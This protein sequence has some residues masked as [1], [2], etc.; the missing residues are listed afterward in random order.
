M[1]RLGQFRRDTLANWQ[2]QN[3]ILADGEFIL[4]AMDSSKPREY[5]KWACGNGTSTFTQLVLKDYG[6]EGNPCLQDLGNSTQFPISQDLATKLINITNVFA[7]ITSE[8]KI[9]IVGNTLYLG[10]FRLIIE[11]FG[12]IDLIGNELAFTITDDNSKLVVIDYNVLKNNLNKISD[13]IYQISLNTTG[14]IKL[15]EINDFNPNYILLLHKH[16]FK[17]EPSGILY[18]A[19]LSKRININCETDIDYIYRFNFSN[20]K[21]ELKSPGFYIK[22]SGYTFYIGMNSNINFNID[23]NKKQYLI[24]QIDECLKYGIKKSANYIE[25]NY[26]NNTNCIKLIS[27]ADIRDIYNKKQLNEIIILGVW[28]KGTYT[29][30]QNN[31]ITKYQNDKIVSASFYFN[32]TPT[33]FFSG[34]SLIIK[35]GVLFNRY[36]GRSFYLLGTKILDGSSNW[37]LDLNVLGKTIPTKITNNYDEYDINTENLIV[38]NIDEGINTLETNRYILLINVYNDSIIRNGGLFDSFINSQRINNNS[39]EIVIKNGDINYIGNTV[40]INKLGFRF[41]FPFWN[42]R[43]LIEN[44]SDEKNP[45]IFNLDDKEVVCLNLSILFEQ[46]NFNGYYYIT[47]LK[48][49]LFELKTSIENLDGYLPLFHS[50]YG[51][52]LPYSGLFST[53]LLKNGKNSDIFDNSYTFNSADTLNAIT[54][55][56]YKWNEEDLSFKKRF[57][58]GFIT[59]CHIESHPNSTENLQEA[60][61][62]LNSLPIKEE[63][64]CIINGGDNVSGQT[65]GNTQRT[66]MKLF[67]EYNKISKV[68]ILPIEG[69]H[70]NNYWKADGTPNEIENCI[71]PNEMR[72]ILTLPLIGNLKNTNIAEDNTYFY[73]DYPDFKIRIIIL[74]YCDT[75]LIE[76]EDGKNKYGKLITF[77]QK[78]INWFINEALNIPNEYGVIVCNHAPFKYGIGGSF[79]QNINMIPEIINAFK[80]GLNINKTFEDISQN[81]FD[82]VVNHDFTS[83]GPQNFMFYLS[84]HTHREYITTNGTYTDQVIV[85]GLNCA[86]VQE[87]DITR[88][89]NSVSKI[90]FNIF[91]IDK[92]ERK[93]YK[94]LYGAWQN[95][96]GT[97]TRVS[98]I[99]F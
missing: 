32:N 61:R 91:C 36:F 73:I 70:D 11:S 14:L 68:P 37:W 3:P 89:Q 75:P 71:S 88:I 25:I 57:N 66:N 48:E 44:S 45:L 58:I 47:E 97:N 79:A 31:L 50:Y 28:T 77:S 42:K 4:I 69:N 33:A 56:F 30:I 90:A 39:V 20:N 52:V 83:K 74:N 38:N 59:D 53:L 96:K 18:N 16:Y 86:C 62:F 5:N 40:Y 80:N 34:K 8:D 19:L 7:E 54:P 93:I 84:G 22:N 55:Y 95:D 49:E 78:Q 99:K 64:Q 82:I 6:G 63:L 98:T 43:I 29:P 13:Q 87:S 17:Y 10:E 65:D 46:M 41:L 76:G 1:A 35:E 92:E 2:S 60:L 51:T 27:D 26:E 81:G 9:N 24:I 72:E 15:T 67:V 21:C 12:R 23:E 85:V 94:A